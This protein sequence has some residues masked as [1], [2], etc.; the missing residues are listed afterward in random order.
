M[1]VFFPCIQTTGRSGVQKI[2]L[3]SQ[4]MAGIWFVWLV[5]FAVKQWLMLSILLLSA[6]VLDGDRL[7][8]FQ[9]VLFTTLV[10]TTDKLFLCTLFT[11]WFMFSEVSLFDIH[12]N[13]GLWILAPALDPLN[14]FHMP[15]PLILWNTVPLITGR[16]DMAP[17]ISMTL[18][19][20]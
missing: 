5:T 20:L 14:G 19:A 10:L 3:W 2:A 4:T 17:H 13:I 7:I 12:A 18:K 15:R 6:H 8:L 11:Y 1:S 9:L 16:A